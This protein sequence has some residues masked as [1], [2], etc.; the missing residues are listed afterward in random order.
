[1]VIFTVLTAY[2]VQRIA[3]G[4]LVQQTGSVEKAAVM[5]ADESA[6]DKA[7]KS[8]TTG[9]T[10]AGGEVS[11]RLTIATTSLNRPARVSSTAQRLP[12][13]PVAPANTATAG[14]RTSDEVGLPVRSEADVGRGGWVMTA[15]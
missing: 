4:D 11:G 2:D 9:R 15:F 1:M 3:A 7:E 13:K 6:P 8:T 12:T 14:W 10:P 5:G